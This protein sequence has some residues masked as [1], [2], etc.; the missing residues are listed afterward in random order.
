MVLATLSPA[1]QALLGACAAAYVGLGTWGLT[2]R[3]GLLTGREARL[4][5]AHRIAAAAAFALAGGLLA[6]DAF[7]GGQLP[8]QSDTVGAAIFSGSTAVLHGVGRALAGTPWE[9]RENVQGS[10]RLGVELLAWGLSAGLLF[11]V[12]LEFT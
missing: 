2:R 8:G 3:L 9:I 12:A 6:R 1:K 7:S 5:S 4:A 10:V 11:V